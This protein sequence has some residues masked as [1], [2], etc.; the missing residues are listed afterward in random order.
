MGL[1]GRTKPLNDHETTAESTLP[2]TLSWPHLIAMG[3]GA[4]IGMGIFTLTG[5]GAALAGPG[6]ILSFALAGIVCALAALAYA[7]VATLIPAAGSAYTYTYSV[8]GEGLAWVVGWA[9]ILEYGLGSSAV[10]AGWSAH[11]NGLLDAWGVHIPYILQ[12]GPWEHKVYDAAGH[13]IAGPGVVDILAVGIVLAVMGLLLI[14]ARES[15]LVNIVLV[16]IK[17]AALGTFIVISVPA[18]KTGNYH[19]FMPYGFWS[20]ADAGGTKIGVMAAA[21]IMF[22]AFYGFDAVSTSAEEAKNPG[23][24]LT[25]GII[26]S[27]VICTIFYMVVGACV[28][29]VLPYTEVAKS[30]GEPLPYILRLMNHGFIADLVGIAAVLAL[31]SVLLVFMFGQSRILFVMARD[32]LIPKALSKLDRRGLPTRM[33]LITGI[34][35]AIFAGLVPL[36]QIAEMA[37]TGTLVAFIA[38]S[39][40]M[41]ILRVTRPELKRAFKVPLFWLVGPLAIAGCVFLFT[42]LN[43][44]TMKF[45]AVWT[46]I[47]IVVYFLYGFWNS[48]LRKAAEAAAE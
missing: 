46:A 45:F 4:I 37:N 48:R 31:P 43:V 7:E 12:H 18:I 41:M 23:R 29:G 1:F 15:A 40:A 5:I 26:G 10:A 22:F 28:V 3:I 42:S 27:M 24:D 13:L 11:M 16:I 35:V 38:V 30:H 19:P 21:A 39:L 8:L 32:G 17:L 33:T 47:G 25:I 2:K 34:F 14:G 44:S 9:L 20:H 36:Q 6:V